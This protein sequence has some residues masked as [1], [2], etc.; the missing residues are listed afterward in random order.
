[1]LQVVGVRYAVIVMKLAE[2]GRIALLLVVVIGRVACGGHAR[3]C[4]A[5]VVGTQVAGGDGMAPPLMKIW[6]RV[7]VGKQAGQCRG[8]IECVLRAELERVGRVPVSAVRIGA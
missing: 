2:R 4:G 3:S 8:I 6:V 1:M 5:G 7:R